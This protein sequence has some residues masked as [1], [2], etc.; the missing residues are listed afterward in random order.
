M[1]LPR[2]STRSQPLQVVTFL[3]FASTVLI[4]IVGTAYTWKFTRWLSTLK[5][6]C[7][8]DI[9]LTLFW[10]FMYVLWF[11]NIVD[12]IFSLL[13]MNSMKLKVLKIACSIIFAAIGTIIGLLTSERNLP[14]FPTLPES[15][16]RRMLP[17][18]MVQKED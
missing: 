1:L 15:Q 7:D 16:L 8:L 17:S 12:T 3:A 10:S 6:G 14:K 13:M 9:E 5:E 18:N 4:V 11:T 2:S